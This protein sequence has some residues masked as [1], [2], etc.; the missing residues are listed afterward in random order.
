MQGLVFIGYSMPD[1]DV[2]LKYLLAV[3]LSGRKTM[4]P[5]LVVN[6][7]TGKTA[8]ENEK[9]EDD[10]RKRYEA[11]LDVEFGD[12]RHLYVNKPFADAIGAIGEFLSCPDSSA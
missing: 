2:H 3:G 1:T 6:C 9:D 8:E 11:A 10:T 12:Q 7:H 5:V 4:P